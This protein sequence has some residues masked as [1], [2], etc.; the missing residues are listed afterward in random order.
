MLLISSELGRR[1]ALVELDGLASSSAFRRAE[2]YL[3]AMQELPFFQGQRHG[4][5]WQ[6]NQNADFFPAAVHRPVWPREMW[7]PVAEFMEAQAA[8]LQAELLWLLQ[9]DPSQE[10]FEIA[11]QQQTEF[12]PHPREWATVDLIRKGEKAEGCRF[13]P[14][15]CELLAGRPEVNSSL[16]ARAPNAGV[17]VARLWPGAEIKPHFATEPR[18]AMHLGL[19]APPGARLFVGGEEVSWAEGRVEVFDDTYVHSVRHE[20]F[21]AR[22]VL[23][24]WVCH[25]CDEEWLGNLTSTWQEAL[26]RPAWCGAAKT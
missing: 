25:P 6:A 13:L 9:A 11:Q 12:S 19:V 2:G 10:L 17:S 26:R 8:A 16:C 22:F 21:E 1:L 15:S 14:R 23:L 3:A 24:A 18:L 4:G 7:P 5:P 20:G